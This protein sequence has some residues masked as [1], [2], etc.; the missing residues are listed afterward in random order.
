MGF[1]FF[2]FFVYP[3][4]LIQIIVEDSHIGMFPEDFRQ[5][6]RYKSAWQIVT[7]AWGVLNVTQALLRTILLYTAPL[8][9]YY[10]VSTFYTNIS[11]PLLLVI[12]YAFPKWYWHRART[13]EDPGISHPS[14]D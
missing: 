9:I 6:R 7:A 3:A 12:S 10:T 14:E 1:D 13:K 5:T 2:R 11:S 8:E 4:A